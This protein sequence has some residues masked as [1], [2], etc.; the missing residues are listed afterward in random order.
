MIS[1]CR[2]L[3]YISG[4]LSRALHVKY[5]REAL[6]VIGIDLSKYAS[7]SF[8]TGVAT[9]AAA[10]GLEDSLIRTLGRWQSSAYI[11]YLLC[12]RIPPER[13]AQIS[14]NLAAAV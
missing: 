11:L 3:S 8:R 4:L 14:L 1:A 7:H 10:S 2:G 13:L 5:L 6:V 12:V 9:T